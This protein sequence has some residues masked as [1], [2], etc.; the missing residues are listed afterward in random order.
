MATGLTFGTVI[1]PAAY[2][3]HLL[4]RSQFSVLAAT[5]RLSA[6]LPG[7]VAQRLLGRA[8]TVA[9][10]PT[11]PVPRPAPDDATVPAGQVAA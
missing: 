6:V 3:A 11:A 10:A 1:N 9:V 8:R 7:A 4:D 2:Q 5:V